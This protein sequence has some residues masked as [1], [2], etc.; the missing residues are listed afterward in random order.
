MFTA[1]RGFLAIYD[2]CV[3]AFVDLAAAASAGIQAPLDG[4]RDKRSETFEQSC[5]KLFPFLCELVNFSLFSSDGLHSVLDQSFLLEQ[6]QE[7]INNA[8]CNVL[9][10]PSPESRE[11]AVA[12]SWA[13]VK[14]SEYVESRKIRN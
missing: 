10:Q 8:W 5:A 9:P 12:V 11:N 14:D 13:F 1:E 7:R 4:S 3:S 2:L 6:L